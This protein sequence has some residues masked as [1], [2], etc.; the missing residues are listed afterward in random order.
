[1]NKKRITILTII[2]SLIT[3]GIF[4]FI[5]KTINVSVLGLIILSQTFLFYC[6]EKVVFNKEKGNSLKSNLPSNIYN[7]ELMIEAIKNN[8]F[9]SFE[10]RS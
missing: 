7:A 3:T 9:D 10:C 2:S 1:M 4:Y 5:T 8:D 6:L